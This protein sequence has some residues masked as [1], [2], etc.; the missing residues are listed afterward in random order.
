MRWGERNHFPHPISVAC[1]VSKGRS[2]TLSSSTMCAVSLE[3]DG[4]QK[5]RHLHV[6]LHLVSDQ[7]HNAEVSTAKSGIC[8]ME[9]VL[10]CASVMP[11]RLSI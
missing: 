1:A 11:C 3:C 9:S 10:W 4:M 2:V 8:V 5:E 6:W 7:V